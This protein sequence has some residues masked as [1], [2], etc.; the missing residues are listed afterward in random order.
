[1]G[2]RA[3]S[4]L[5][6]L[7]AAIAAPG[8]YCAGGEQS[9][10]SALAALHR[11]NRELRTQL[12]KTNDELARMK[13]WLAGMVSGE[14]ELDSGKQLLMENRFNSAVRL[15]NTLV[16]KSSEASRELRSLLNELQLDKARKIRYMMILDELDSAAAAFS[17]NAVRSSLKDG[18]FRVIAIDRKLQT[19]IISGGL[20]DGIAP[21]MV[22]RPVGKPETDLRLR[23][24]SVRP[25]A[26]AADFVSGKWSELVTGMAVTPF[27][28]VQK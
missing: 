2:I 20:K 14:A 15:G 28:L 3:K 23:V 9:G 26:C 24:I 22:F 25:E 6:L 7:I 10:E 5:L 16:L 19:V 27:N 8:A 11:E 12:L 18:D 13:K 17:G 1:M 21:G 4:V